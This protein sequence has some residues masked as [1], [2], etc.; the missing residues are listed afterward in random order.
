M[1][2]YN[3]YVIN[4]VFYSGLINEN[5]CKIVIVYKFIY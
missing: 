1:Y 3:I 4:N 5:M 2:M